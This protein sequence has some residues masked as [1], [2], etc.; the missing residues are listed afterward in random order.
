MSDPVPPND[1]PAEPGPPSAA[2]FPSGGSAPMGST[3]PFAPPTPAPA[4]PQHPQPQQPPVWSQA[5]APQSGDPTAAPPAWS[6]TGAPAAVVTGAPQPRRERNVVAIVAIGL[7]AVGTLASLL[8]TT[9][10]IGWILLPVSF[11]LAIVA[12]CLRDKA[13][14]L[15]VSA[16]VLS[17]VGSLVGLGMFA[18][19]VGRAIMEQQGSGLALSVDAPEGTASPI[20]PTS[21]TSEAEDESF[22]GTVL[23]TRE[24]TLRILD[25]RIYEAGAPGND[26][27]DDD[28]IAF[29]YEVTNKSSD[30]LTA[31]RAWF[32]FR[33]FQDN[34][35]NT[36]NELGVGLAPDDV[37]DFDSQTETIKVGGTVKGVGAFTLDDRETPVELVAVSPSTYEELGRATF[38]LK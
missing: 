35:P 15:A 3:S 10:V 25:H 6:Q 17:I 18:Y 34:D 16:L 8:Q 22:D 5:P 11:V 29:T 1:A 32:A 2:P 23:E 21:P 28:I 31:L 14:K 38:A 20:L 27:N 33:A 36:V 4:V 26:Y 12:L 7:A 13:K 9:A 24:F 30:D 19:W 37:V